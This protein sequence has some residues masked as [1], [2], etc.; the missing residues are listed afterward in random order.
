MQSSAG[1]NPLQ[2]VAQICRKIWGQGQSGQAIKLLR[3]PRKKNSFTFHFGH[4]SFILDD[5]KLAELSK[6]SFE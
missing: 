2:P 6:N 5:V 4:K 1:A 3:T